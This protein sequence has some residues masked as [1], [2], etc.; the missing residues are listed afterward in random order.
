MC[1]AG[2]C[3]VGTVNSALRKPVAAATT[4]A[5]RSEAPIGARPIGEGSAR[6]PR[7]GC[8]PPAC[9]AGK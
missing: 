3:A 7:R 4:M 5:A 2:A 1:V 9:R 6:P 8:T